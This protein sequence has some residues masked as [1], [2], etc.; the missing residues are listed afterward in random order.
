MSIIQ[1]IQNPVLEESEL[2]VTLNEMESALIKD[3]LNKITELSR[4]T[5]NVIITGEPGVGK[6]WI[7]KLLHVLGKDPQTCFRYLH[8]DQYKSSWSDFVSVQLEKDLNDIY[9]LNCRCNV[10]IN[11]FSELTSEGQISL[12]STI[13]DVRNSQEMNHIARNNQVRY[14]FTM[15]GQWLKSNT[16]K[17]V[18]NYLFDLLNP[19]SVVIP[20]LREHREDITPLS[21]LFLRQLTDREYKQT[22]SRRELKISNEALFKCIS[23][24]WPGN[25]RQLKNAITHAYLCTTDNVIKREDLPFSIDTSQVFFPGNTDGYKSWSYVKAQQLLLE[26]YKP[27]DGR[28]SEVSIKSMLKKIISINQ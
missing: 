4:T 13:L 19:V 1:H 3:I 7:A 10:L 22:E 21:N 15:S 14:F 12:L 18:W 17:Y 23:Y 20:P 9:E 24:E 25:I 27:G 26:S 5:S 6:H 11:N 2:Q 8:C 16:K 28:M